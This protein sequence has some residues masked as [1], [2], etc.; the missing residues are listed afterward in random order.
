[1]AI[2]K[3]LVLDKQETDIKKIMSKLYRFS[4]EL[5]FTLSNLSLEDNLGKSVLDILETRGERTRNLQFDSDG[6]EIS[7]K[8]LESKTRASLTQTQE[9]ISLLVEKG[10]V[11]ETM[12][13]RMELYGEY[14][15][16]KTGQVV[17][18]AQNM[19]LNKAGDAYFSGTIN[20]GSININNQFIVDALGN[21]SVGGGMETE[22]LNPPGGVYAEEL[23]VYNDNEVINTVTGNVDCD[24]AWISETLNCRRAYQT[25]DARKKQMV[26][27]I[28]IEDAAE[29]IKG[30]YP[31]RYRWGRS[32][33]EA[34]GF[35]AQDVRG[36]GE[37]TGIKL[38]GQEG[39]I[40]A[41]PYGSYEAL[42]AAAIQANQ[43]RIERLKEEI[44]RLRDGEL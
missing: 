36:L 1:M 43:R 42:Y 37:R 7:F 24:E 28:V 5:K 34:V 6:L 20:G 2:Y 16:L 39:G 27:E 12:I 19:T 22:T 26:R 18:E 11:V 21:C 8:N 9:K 33:R 3:P 14:I 13:S 41:L 17:I 30:M 40:L 4:Q 15:T 38:A 23:E 10:D 44:R 35:V 32:G 25:S 31:V 29:I